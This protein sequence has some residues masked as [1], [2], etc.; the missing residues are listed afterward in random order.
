M[1]IYSQMNDYISNYWSLH[2]IPQ[3]ERFTQL[4]LNYHNILKTI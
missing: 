4:Q 1:A 2:L 3:K